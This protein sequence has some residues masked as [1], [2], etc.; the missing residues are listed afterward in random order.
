VDPR[1]A[2]RRRAAAKVAC[3]LGIA[4]TV[5][6]LLVAATAVVL[7]GPFVLHTPPS[8]EAEPASPTRLKETVELLSVELHP[9]DYTQAANL[10]RAAK[11]IAEQMSAAGLHVDEQPYHVRLDAASPGGSYRNVIGRREGTDPGAGVVII[12]AHYDA[13]SGSPGADDNASAI[14]VLLELARTLPSEPP[15]R[16]QLLVAFSTEEPPFFATKGMGSHAYVQHLLDQGTR[17]RLMVAMDL[18]G[19]YNDSLGSQRY[20]LPGMGLLYPKRGNFIAVVGD[21]RSGGCIHTV[22]RGMLSADSIPVVSARAPALIPGV[23]WSD[24]IW[25]RRK[26]FPGVLV[27]DTAF[28]RNPNYHTQADTMD[29]LDYE[30][31]AQLVK[32]LHGVLREADRED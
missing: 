14:A 1:F 11:W 29:T 30:R 18:V 13:V 24:H 19:Y 31:M 28:L 7:R 4:I 23:H 2:R 26:G 10:D 27:T 9:R 22:K 20:L 3:V 5:I 12:G 32:A 8:F 17:V 25:F 21:L 15:R 16:T 6:V